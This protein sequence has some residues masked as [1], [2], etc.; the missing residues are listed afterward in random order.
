MLIG[1][2]ADFNRRK[3]HIAATALFLR[4]TI[5]NA[6]LLLRIMSGVTR[7]DGPWGLRRSV[8]WY[9]MNALRLIFLLDR[10]ELPLNSLLLN[11]RIPLPFIC[12]NRSIPVRVNRG[13]AFWRCSRSRFLNNT[14][15]TTLVKT[16]GAGFSIVNPNIGDSQIGVKV[17]LFFRIVQYFLNREGSRRV[18]VVSH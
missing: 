14:D 17:K 3:R 7:R 11:L 8:A 13:E 10:R 5:M 2:T 6:V 12:D 18:A 9:G 15:S 1:R 16:I 4:D